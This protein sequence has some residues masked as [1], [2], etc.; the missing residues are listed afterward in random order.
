MSGLHTYV[1]EHLDDQ[2]KQAS[3]YFCTAISTS[4]LLPN[5]LAVQVQGRIPDPILRYWE[6]ELTFPVLPP[7]PEAAFQRVA[8]LYLQCGR[9]HLGNRRMRVALHRGSLQ[10]PVA[11]LGEGPGKTENRNGVVF[12]GPAGR[13]QNTLIQGVGINPAH[14]NW[15]NLVGCRP[16]DGRHFPD[17]PPNTVEKIACSERLLLMLRAIR[18]SVVVCLGKQACDL[19]WDEPPHPWT[20]HQLPHGLIVGHARHPSYLLR[21]VAVRGGEAERIAAVRFYTALKERMPYLRKLPAWP[22]PIRYLGEILERGVMV[23][24]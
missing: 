6:H 11:F 2:T 21:R 13:L 18:P 9:C 1:T 12:S 24:K 16:C 10:S 17:R 5:D 15:L 14:I 8:H 19:F 23:G 3:T 7:D 4:R 20:W 22:V